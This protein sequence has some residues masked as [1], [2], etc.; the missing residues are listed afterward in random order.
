MRYSLNLSL[1]QK[2]RCLYKSLTITGRACIGDICAFRKF[3]ID[4]LDRTDCCLERASVVITVE[5]IKKASILSYQ[6]SLCRG[7]SGI[8][9]KIAVTLIACQI[10]CCN[11]VRRLAFVK[12]FVIFLC[13]KQRLHT[14][15]FEVKLN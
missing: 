3:G 11:F 1:I 9:T 13:R 15:Y 12:C 5:G 4:F 14:L 10:A 8:D 6:C 7:R 2:K